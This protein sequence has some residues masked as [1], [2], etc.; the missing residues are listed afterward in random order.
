M[1]IT[2]EISGSYAC[3][4]RPE[5]KVERVSY[6]VITPSA[7]R[8]IVEAVFWKP[9]IRWVIDEI[10]VCKPIVFETIRRNEV[11]KKASTPHPIATNEERT[12]RASLI[13]KNVCYLVTAHFE[14]TSQ[15]TEMDNK[16]KFADM[17]KRRLRKGQFYHKP[18]L[19][20]REF[21]AEVR[22]IERNEDAPQPINESRSLG[23]MLYDVDYLKDEEGNVRAFC[24]TFFMGEMKNGV[25]DLRE[26]EV[27]R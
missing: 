8:G 4:S 26:V 1:S 16:G 23:L 20:V 14:M 5:L 17:V 13:L 9:A 15:A 24:P 25:M 27:L 10:S 7:A 2:I 21:P 12:Q 3:F 22:L 19:G 11:K 6:E 18:Y